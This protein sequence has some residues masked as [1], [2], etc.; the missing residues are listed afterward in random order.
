MNTSTKRRKAKP[1]D[2]ELECGFDEKNEWQSER[3]GN[4]D[5]INAGIFLYKLHGSIDWVRES[6]TGILKRYDSP[7]KNAE[8]I[9]GTDA[10]L[11][12]IDPFL[13][14]VYEL[15]NYSLLCKMIV[16][17]GYSFNDSHINGLL[18]QALRAADRKLLVVDIH[19]DYTDDILKKLFLDDGFRPRIIFKQMT[20]GQFLNAEL[21]KDKME[22]LIPDEDAV[23]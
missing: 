22:N 12:S 10:K 8:L 20:A 17:I 9:F 14:N 1:T 23:F 7:Q 3:L 19:N 5:Q 4:P 18:G 6:D 21:T 15:R 16:V 13:F 2:Y 11:Q